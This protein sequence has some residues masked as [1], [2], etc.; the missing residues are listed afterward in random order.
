MKKSSQQFT[1]SDRE[2]S[3]NN[4]VNNFKYKT[5]N[6]NVLLN[7]VRLEKKKNFTKK[8]FLT[9]LIISAIS[10]SAFIVLI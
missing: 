4:I 6:I 8:I 5:T 7:R 2:T 3:K 1:A 9:S 10:I